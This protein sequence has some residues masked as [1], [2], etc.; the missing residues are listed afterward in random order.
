VIPEHKSDSLP[1]VQGFFF[2]SGGEKIIFSGVG[3]AGIN[4]DLLLQIYNSACQK[5]PHIDAKSPG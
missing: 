4:N 3:V 5:S 2:E 1:V